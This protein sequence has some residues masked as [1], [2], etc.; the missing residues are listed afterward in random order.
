MAS[1]Q[2]D[3]SDGRL[4]GRKAQA[5]RLRLWTKSPH[6]ARCGRLTDFPDGFQLDHKVALANKGEDTDENLQVLCIGPNGCHAR[7][8]AEDYGH[9]F[10]PTIGEDGF[11]VEHQG[12]VSA[13]A[14][15]G[16]GGVSGD[17]LTPRT[18]RPEALF[19]TVKL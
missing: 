19:C 2:Y 5:R 4:R 15:E 6:C 9:R 16:G 17:N 1:A 3:N 18:P 12:G 13:K 14:S 7:K 10:Q 11:P 8:T